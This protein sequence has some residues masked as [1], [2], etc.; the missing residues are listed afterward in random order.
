MSLFAVRT[1]ALAAAALFARSLRSSAVM[2]WRLA[3]PPFRAISTRSALVSARARALPPFE[4]PSL[5]IATACGF[6]FTLGAYPEGARIRHAA[7]R[8]VNESATSGPGVN[9]L[10]AHLHEQVSCSN[11]VLR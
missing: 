5:L 9:L 7:A 10:A 1:F 2:L 6:F 4:A 3:F 11:I 8:K